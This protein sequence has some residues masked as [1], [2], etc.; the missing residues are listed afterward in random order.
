MRFSLHGG[1]IEEEEAL[2]EFA[3]RLEAGFYKY[4]ALEG[5]EP[6]LV[7]QC[8]PRKLGLLEALEQITQW[9][10]ELPPGHGV[11]GGVQDPLP[12]L[13]TPPCQ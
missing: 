5:D 13:D 10:D 1:S 6:V 4:E 9:L 12:G 7:I 2:R 8:L 11:A 3:R